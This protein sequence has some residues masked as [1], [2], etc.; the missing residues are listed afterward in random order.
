MSR[1][2]YIFGSNYEEQICYFHSI[3]AYK[4]I[5]NTVW[6]RAR[7]CTLQQKVH[8]TRSTASDKDYQLLGYDRWFSPGTLASSTTKTVRYD[9]ASDN[10]IF[11]NT[12]WIHNSHNAKNTYN[13]IVKRKW[14]TRQ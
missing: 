4:P 13:T 11:Y 7:L 9:I 2:I 10:M 3:F 14:T 8:S 12:K 5:T 1:N 6:V